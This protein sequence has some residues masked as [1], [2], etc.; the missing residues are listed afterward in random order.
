MCFVHVRIP[1]CTLLDCQ[2]YS[3]SCILL[4]PHTISLWNNLPNSVVIPLAHSSTPYPCTIVHKLISFCWM[5]ARIS[6]MC[7]SCIPCYFAKFTKI[8]KILTVCVTIVLVHYKLLPTLIS[9]ATLL[10]LVLMH[11]H[12]EYTDPSTHS[13][14]RV[15]C[16]EQLV[17]SCGA[18][19]L[20]DL[21]IGRTGSDVGNQ[22]D[23]HGNV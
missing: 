11:W 22:A 23:G 3:D 19:P 12:T 1:H 4:F 18:G 14:K 21:S 16:S 20:S 6:F 2:F 13:K 7:C 15:W 5:Y 17:L 10:R 9:L 8:K